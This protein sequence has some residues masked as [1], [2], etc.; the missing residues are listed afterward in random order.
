MIKTVLGKKLSRTLLVA[1]ALALVLFAGALICRYFDA[2]TGF[3]FGGGGAGIR[4]RDVIWVIDGKEHKIAAY[5]SL[6]KTNVVFLVDVPS[7]SPDDE[8]CNLLVGDGWIA[9]FNDSGRLFMTTPLFVIAGETIRYPYHLEDDVKGWGT[10]YRVAEE[11]DC[12]VFDIL[13]APPHHPK[14]IRLRIPM[15]YLRPSCA[16]S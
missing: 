2:L 3:A 7:S 6:G 1:A 8:K 12:L 16:S 10:R 14:S 9:R 13:P 4:I 15:K 5:R 11:E